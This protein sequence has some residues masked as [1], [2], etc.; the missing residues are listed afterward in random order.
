MGAPGSLAC[1]KLLYPENE[2][3]ITK[4]VEDL[5]LPPRLRYILKFK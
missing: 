2:E 3:S 1:S 4:G 5:D